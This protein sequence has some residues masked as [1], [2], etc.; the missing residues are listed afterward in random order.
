M[1]ESDEVRVLDG[2]IMVGEADAKLRMKCRLLTFASSPQLYQ[3]ALVLHRD[4]SLCPEVLA[5]EITQVLCLAAVL[6]QHPRLRQRG[7]A[8]EEAMEHGTARSR[9][10]ASPSS[11]AVAACSP[12]RCV[13]CSLTCWR[14]STSSSCPPR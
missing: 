10:R 8:C 2:H 13:V 14:T 5:F 6:L 7:V 3:S 11:A 1:F 9:A 12:R 4:G